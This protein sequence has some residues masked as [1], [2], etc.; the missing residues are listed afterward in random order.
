MCRHGSIPISTILRKSV[1]FFT[2]SQEPRKW[3]LRVQNT[4][5]GS[6]QQTHLEAFAFGTSFKNRSPFILDR[7][8]VWITENK[9]WLYNMACSSLA[10]S[11]DQIQQ[12]GII[13]VKTKKIHNNFHYVLCVHLYSPIASCGPTF[14]HN[15]NVNP[16]LGREH[17]YD[18]INK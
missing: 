11:L 17:K 14:D 5:W 4:I 2:M 18:L 9:L 13:V 12:N 6:M 7:H 1:R 16:S 10:S 8:L 15:K 3:T